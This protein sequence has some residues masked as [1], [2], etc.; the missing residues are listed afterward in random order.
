LKDI[1]GQPLQS[2]ARF[3]EEYAGSIKF[4]FVDVGDLTAEERKVFTQ[5]DA[6]AKVGGGRPKSVRE[7]LVSETMR[8]SVLEGLH[9]VGFW[10]EPTG[11]VIVHRPVL[12]SL[13]R[14]AGTILHEFAHANSG[15]PDVSRNF[16]L[17]LTDVI[18][19]L[20][21]TLVGKQDAE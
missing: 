11:R 17:A 16:E 20:A 13:R 14:F 21:T 6:I 9:P 5:L 8:P 15:E 3:A 19:I 4:K 18:G 12:R 10:D 2:L 7:V 1:A